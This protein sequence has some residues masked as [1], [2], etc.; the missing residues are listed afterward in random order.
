M[1]RPGDWVRLRDETQFDYPWDEIGQVVDVD[2]R[3]MM[4]QVRFE[5]GKESSEPWISVFDLILIGHG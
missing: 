5:D 1:L 4:V 3:A 2:T